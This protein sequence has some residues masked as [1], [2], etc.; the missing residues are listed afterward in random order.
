P[1]PEMGS[2]DMSFVMNEVPGAYF[3]VS[4]CPAQD[5]RNAPTNHSPRAEL[6]D[7]VVPDAAAWYAEFALRRTAQVPTAQVGE[8][9]GWACPPTVVPPRR[10]ADP[11]RRW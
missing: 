5:Y 6:D 10:A 11:W 4:A 3:F 1:T 7:V 8:E 2:E 9:E